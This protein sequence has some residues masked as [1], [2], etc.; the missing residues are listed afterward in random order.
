M[1]DKE[2]K[3]DQDGKM[4][5][6]HNPDF[7]T[8]VPWYLGNSGPTLKHHSVQKADH[9]LS[10]SESD[11]L[12]ERKLAAQKA[13][14]QSAPKTVYRK[15]A[16]KNCGAMTH[17][18]KDC[19]ERPRSSKKSAWKSGLDIA[20]DEVTMKLEDHGKV[21]YDAK[22][23]QWKGYDA[24]EYQAIIDKHERLEQE[25]VKQLKEQKEFQKREL[26]DK[27]RRK[28]ELKELDKAQKQENIE[29]KQ[30][31][32]AK[33]TS[34]ANGD[35]NNNQSD[36]SDNSDSDSD[37]GS[38]EE[39]DADDGAVTHRDFVERDEEA[40]DFQGT[41]APQGGIGG[42]GMRQTV[43][44]LRLREDTPKYLRNLALDSA[45]YDPKSRAMRA[46]PLPDENPEDLAFAGDNFIRY[47]GDA[48][49]LAQNQLLCW[50]MQ[51]RGE[52]ID[53]I[54]NPSQAELLQRQFV[55]KKK[56]LEQSRQAAILAKYTDGKAS[57]A[58]D[59]RLRLGQTEAY[60]EY[61]RDGRLVKGAPTVVVRTKYEE[62]LFV[63]NHTSVWGSYYNRARAVWGYQC[64]HS[65]M[66]NSYCTGAKGRQAND[67]ANSEAM[68]AFQ[69]RKMLDSATKKDAGAGAGA[70]ALTKRSDIFGESDAAATSA[71]D[72][73]KLKKAHMKAESLDAA[74]RNSNGNNTGSSV[75][76]GDERKRGYN[77]MQ[78]V[79]VTAEDME[80]YRMK[81]VKAD[82]PMAALLDS[83]EILE[84]KK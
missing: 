51:A 23:D 25:R 68:D 45:F 26:E 8:K 6:P 41:M 3:L 61:N 20:P 11:A 39:D 17:N 72:A 31:A 35:N 55:D 22:R 37:Y 62:D 49:K 36:S 48:V 28:K 79:D 53:V 44:N 56:K 24:L 5:N 1:T 10:L 32:K 38:D 75:G 30:A 64:C 42:N 13:S 71:L 50:E 84:Y 57:T 21:S 18:E 73:E 33:A 67:A 54:S 27:Q 16:C 83:E 7:I 65:C 40:R 52:S 47:S 66:R 70:Q 77:S 2:P 4:I 19:V 63:N 9:F 15:G 60:V 80:V 81:K 78:S 59:P 58:M 12:I 74:A 29:R 43:R 34:K 69:A 82:D 46:N 14:L 76:D